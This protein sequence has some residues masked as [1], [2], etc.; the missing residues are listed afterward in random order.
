[1]KA[2]FFFAGKEFERR[3]FPCSKMSLPWLNHTINFG[4]N[5]SGIHIDSIHIKRVGVFDDDGFFSQ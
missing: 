3:S 4:K 1:M 5:I 2:L